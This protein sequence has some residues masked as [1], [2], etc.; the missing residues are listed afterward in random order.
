MKTASKESMPESETAQTSECRSPR[1]AT[2]T[3]PIHHI[4]INR[5][6]HQR[7]SK[8]LCDDCLTRIPRKKVEL[9][10]GEEVSENLHHS[11]DRSKR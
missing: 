7:I 2:Q 9:A 10:M 6:L 4:G 8:N 1:S 11:R 5:N 3:N